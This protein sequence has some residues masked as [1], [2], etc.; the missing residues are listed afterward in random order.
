MIEKENNDFQKTVE[1][2]QVSL[3]LTTEADWGFQAGTKPTRLGDR[4]LPR[5]LPSPQ[6][7]APAPFPLATTGCSI[8]VEGLAVRVVFKL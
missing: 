8:L 1:S 6:R 3:V 4:V 2:P 7:S 5:P